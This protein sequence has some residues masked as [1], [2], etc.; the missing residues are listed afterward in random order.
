MF[1]LLV[2]FL[3]PHK[4][5]LHTF[6]VGFLISWRVCIFLP[7]LFIVSSAHRLQFGVVQVLGERPIIGSLD[8]YDFCHKFWKLRHRLGQK[9]VWLASTLRQWNGDDLMQSHKA[10]AA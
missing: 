2:S 10:E 6:P 9:E 4:K 1:P 7:A 3:S 5:S 8:L